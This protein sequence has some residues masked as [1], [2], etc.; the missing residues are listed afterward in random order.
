[1]PYKVLVRTDPYERE[2]KIIIFLHPKPFSI[3]VVKLLSDGWLEKLNL[4]SNT[5]FRFKQSIKRS[6]YIIYYWFSLS[7]YCYNIPIL[8]KSNR[9]GKIY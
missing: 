5:K 4:N 8:V 2:G 1:M 7:N 9:K 6:D 3:L